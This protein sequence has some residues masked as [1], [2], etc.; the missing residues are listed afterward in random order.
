MEQKRG[1]KKKRKR[2]KETRGQAA[3][4]RGI[5]NNPATRRYR[6]R[7]FH[8]SPLLVGRFALPFGE[9]ESSDPIIPP[10][11]NIYEE[12]EEKTGG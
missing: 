3:E 1:D 10:Q 4:L 5:G 2:K 9:R 7:T 6:E 8:P 11:E 12:E